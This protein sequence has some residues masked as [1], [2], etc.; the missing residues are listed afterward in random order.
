MWLLLC[1]LPAQNF[2]FWI[3]T[4]YRG[5]PLPC[6]WFLRSQIR[7]FCDVIFQPLECLAEVFM[8][9]V[10]AM[11]ALFPLE[12]IPHWFTSGVWWR[13]TRA[14]TWWPFVWMGCPRWSPFFRSS[15]AGPWWSQE[16]LRMSLRAPGSRENAKEVIFFAWCNFP[17]FGIGLDNICAPLE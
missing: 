15:M 8:R 11:F 4:C 3:L 17:K 2:V 7:N 16:S 5:F 1:A 13:W 14:T 9:H 10:M 6:P 12:G